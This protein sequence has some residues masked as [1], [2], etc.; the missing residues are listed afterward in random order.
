VNGRR[1][2]VVR[3]SACLAWLALLLLTGCSGTSER[4][5]GWYV[6]RT[7]DG[8]FDF[9]SEQKREVR[10]SVDESI[11]LVR[12]EELPPW[13]NLL[14]E[15]RQGIHDGL[16]EP[17]VE[18][19]QRRYDE[20]IEIAEQLLTP[21]AAPLLAKLGPAQLDHFEKRVREQLDDQYEDLRDDSPEER[22]EK[23]EERALDLIEDFVGNLGDQQAQQVRTLIR[24]LPD[25][26]EAQYRTARQNLAHFRAFMASAPGADA[27]AA[28]LHAMWVRRYEGLGA[29]H[30]KETRRAQQRAWLLSVY[31]LLDAEQRAHAEEELS[32]RIRALKRWVLPRP[33]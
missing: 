28:E 14:R 13:I 17:K 22:A 27:I 24:Q 1:P 7:L 32:D 23:L 16:D 3:G 19:L 18:R 9:T 33:E 25:E 20:R 5:V 10:A 6:T 2:I 31:R 8:Y 15:A 29:G 11:A 12:R 26:R 30:D 21:R 4:I